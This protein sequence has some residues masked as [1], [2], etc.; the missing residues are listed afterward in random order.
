[1]M[2][3]IEDLHK[4]YGDKVL[5]QSINCTISRQDRIGLIG[6]NGTGKSTFLK[7]VA[8]IERAESGAI[9]HPKDY[10]VEYLAQEPELEEER[11]VM[12]HIYYGDATMMITI[13]GYEQ[14]LQKLD[15]DPNNEAAQAHLMNMQQQMDADEA[16]EANTAAKIILT[17]LGIQDFDKQITTL[18]GGQKK[19]VDRKSTRLNSSHV[20]ISY[21]VFCLK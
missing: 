21:A 12:E 13:R 8:G 10:R 15:T 4:S 20:A 1:M 6:V 14:A 17:K 2:L 16:W 5:F 7:A 9:K 11:T 3:T 18:S 19:R